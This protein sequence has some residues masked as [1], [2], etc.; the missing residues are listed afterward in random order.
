MSSM[1]CYFGLI[2]ICLLLCLKTGYAQ[3]I[4]A[5]LS[6]LDKDI[7]NSM[8]YV[9]QKQERIE[10]LKK[11]LL[12]SPIG[13]ERYIITKKIRE[14]YNKFDSDSALNYAYR[15][16]ELGLKEQ[17]IDLQQ[18]AELSIIQ[19]CMRSNLDI[20]AKELLDNYT[21]FEKVH[22]TV[23]PLYARILMEQEYNTY[24]H[25]KDTPLADKYKKEMQEIWAN[26]QIYLINRPKELLIMD[27]LIN[28]GNAKDKSHEL[29]LFLN[30]EPENSQDR[31]MLEYLLGLELL[32]RNEEEKGIHYMIK[33][34]RHDIKL[35]FKEASALL[36]VMHYVSQWSD[37]GRAFNYA[38]F[39]NKNIHVYKDT[40]RSMDLLKIQSII[41]QRYQ[42]N[43]KFYIHVLWIT[44]FVVTVLCIIILI[45]F[46]NIR[47]KERRKKTAYEK[48]DVMNHQ[49]Q[50]GNDRLQ[51]QIE[52][53]KEMKQ[54]ILQRN[55]Q[56]QQEIQKRESYTVDI[57][58][59]CSDYIYELT[60]FR[61]KINTMLKNG[62][63]NEAKRMSSTAIL[64]DEELEKLHRQFDKIFISTHPDFIKRFNELLQDEEQIA[65]KNENILT[66][67]LRIYALTCLGITD[68][69][70]IA[71]FLHYS[72]QTIYNYR[73]KI[74][75]AARIPE[76]KFEQAVKNLY[77]N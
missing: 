42:K 15:T 32:N 63:L 16:L 60:S 48:I 27:C 25:M 1:K 30:N 26:Y 69:I 3:S 9:N 18:E 31:P 23:R 6:L 59:L 62:M 33:A 64:S 5:E 54:E 74:R 49:L 71:N 47:V 52:Q 4:E 12:N 68:G 41:Q 13:I 43:I 40:S 2:V 35:A 29:E 67:E 39:L 7:E 51:Q 61:K 73:H 19:I 66:P 14:E 50:K 65:V 22:E 75:R 36:I 21:P 17:R 58:Y 28:T 46:F 8:N 10:E 70:K 76:E 45:L 56:L 34:A 72:P 37:M 24:Q 77:V 53:G 20:M 38:V 11:D 44:L 57:F 55:I